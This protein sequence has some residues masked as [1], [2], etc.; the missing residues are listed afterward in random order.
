MAP[1]A[2]TWVPPHA[3]RSRPSMLTIRMSPERLDGFRNPVAE[4]SVLE[5]DR[6]GP[7]LGNDLVGPLLS[8][9]DLF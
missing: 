1:V 8:L 5:C 6:D 7:V 2:V 3:L 4:S 9:S